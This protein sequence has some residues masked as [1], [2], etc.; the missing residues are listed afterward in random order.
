MLLTITLTL[1]QYIIL[2]VVIYIKYIYK[3][4]MIILTLWKEQVERVELYSVL[5]HQLSQ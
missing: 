5:V 2:F 4:R 3:C 1:Q